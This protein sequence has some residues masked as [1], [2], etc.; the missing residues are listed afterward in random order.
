MPAGGVAPP[1]RWHR[2]AC[3]T[4]GGLCPVKLTK[5]W[6]PRPDL[7]FSTGRQGSKRRCDRRLRD[8]FQSGS[9]TDSTLDLQN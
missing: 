8:F 9:M 1:Q 2:I 7:V 3:V 4:A 5:R 6:P